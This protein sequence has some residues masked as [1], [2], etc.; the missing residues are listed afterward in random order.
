MAAF[1]R[2]LLLLAPVSAHRESGA[3]YELTE[4]FRAIQ[5]H[6]PADAV[7]AA[8]GPEAGSLVQ[9]NASAKAPP[10]SLSLGP[11]TFCPSGIS[12]A[13]KFEI[14]I[15][16]AGCSAGVGI[17]DVRDGISVFAAAEASVA[18][19]ASAQ[20]WDGLWRNLRTNVHDLPHIIPGIESAI[21]NAQKVIGTNEESSEV[22][23]LLNNN[24]YNV[25]KDEVL[26]EGSLI[27]LKL[28]AA[29]GIGMKAK[30]CAGWKD[31]D[32]FRNVGAGV[33]MDAG[34]ELSFELVVGVRDEPG[35]PKML[36]I[37]LGL[38]GF[39]FQITT[40]LP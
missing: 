32:N 33:S 29:T 1:L 6:H 12:V 4:T 19:S 18:V 27:D 11:F 13:P 36:R 17:G 40:D 37:T 9:V 20:T 8:A 5:L 30:I 10:W 16:V 22:A 21:E 38:C 24:G 34:L 7:P 23:K 26:K 39:M 35:L 31:E 14:S 15:A 25:T 3:P 28:K 2:L